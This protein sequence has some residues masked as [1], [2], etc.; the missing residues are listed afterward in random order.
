MVKLASV[1]VSPGVS[2]TQPVIVYF[3]PGKSR[4]VTVRLGPPV[5]VALV[6]VNKLWV[7]DSA[8]AVETD[9]VAP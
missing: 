4:P 7:P 2:M 9:T 5:P 6:V 3:A 8:A 1:A